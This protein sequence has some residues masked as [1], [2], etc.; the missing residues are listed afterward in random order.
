VGKIDFYHCKKGKT[1]MNPKKTHDCS[2]CCLENI[3]KVIICPNCQY[4]SCRTCVEKFLLDSVNTDP[5]CM[6]CHQEWTDEF[7][8][9]SM[10][11]AFHNKRYRDKTTEILLEREKSLLPATLPAVEREKKRRELIKNKDTLIAVLLEEQYEIETALMLKKEEIRRVRNNHFDNENVE[12]ERKKFIQQC[13]SE[14]CRGFLSSVWKCGLCEKWFCK[15]CHVA[16]NEQ[17][18]D[19]HECDDDLVST[20]ALLK[21]DTKPCPACMIPITKIN[22][23]DQMFCQA[24][25][26]PIWL[27]NGMKKLAAD[28][29]VGDELIGED[30]FPV[31]V[32]ATTCGEAPLYEVHQKMGENYKVIGKHLMTLTK[33]DVVVDI[34]VEDF[35]KLSERNYH[36]YVCQTINWPEQD[37]VIDPYILGLWLGDGTSRG[38]GFASDDVEI[39]QAWYNWSK[40]NDAEVVHGN[41]FGYMIRCKNQGIRLPVGVN[42]MAT[43]TGCLKKP[44]LTC[45]SSDEL[46]K[47]LTTDRS[48]NTMNLTTNQFTLLKDDVKM[49][50]LYNWRLTTEKEHLN[51]VRG[52]NRQENPLKAMLRTYNLL[53]NKHIPADYLVNG[54]KVRRELLAGLI[55]TD[56]NLGVGAYRFSQ[57]TKRLFNE[58]VDLSRSL[59]LR[60]LTNVSFPQC[61]KQH[62]LRIMG[63][64]GD[65]PVRVARKKGVNRAIRSTISI[66]E[67]GTGAYTG[68]SVQGKTPRYLLGDG[69]VT[70]NC[71]SC[72][73]PFSWTR[74]VVVTGV[75]HNPH[76]Y[77][78]QREQNGGTAPR[79]A[80]DV[81]AYNDPCGDGLIPYDRVCFT[82]DNHEC[83]KPQ[84]FNEMHRVVRHIR[85]VTLI[86][87]PNALTMDNNEDLR[88]KYLM[89]TIDED[90]WKRC[91][92]MREKR[93]A[94]NRAVHLVLD[95]FTTTMTGMF[96]DLGEAQRKDEIKNIISQMHELREYT[97]RSLSA[98]RARFKNVVPEITDEWGI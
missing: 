41:P 12:I 71:T 61:S 98:I 26:T 25:D 63:N 6:N 39:I 20:V 56:G 23:C 1:K 44:S 46:A 31:I 79:V 27:W 8:A 80:G 4:V 83:K 9:A 73:V 43:C 77:A 50:E 60:V 47:L 15:D 55:D 18:D 96:N 33:N 66:T 67:C 11:A 86:N 10:P 92:K 30:G 65:I 14:D 68:W 2:V 22:G 34:T 59:G 62:S 87:Y 84:Y 57:S 7:L 95:M 48:K 24:D 90:K 3:R 91:L 81:P 36:S 76:F 49:Q 74:G 28:I 53:D 29:K 37:V 40:L 97:N 21:K 5:E 58:V 70:H 78:W 52:K 38:D 88:V 45:A 35:C 72:H 13:P 89:S 16:K 94:K 69:T 85:R 51:Q 42:T 32:T 19:D 54:V 93:R 64:I 82:L 75:I 17:K